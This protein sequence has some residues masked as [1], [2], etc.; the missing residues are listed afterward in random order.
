MTRMIRGSVLLAACVGLWSCSSDPTA[1]EAGVP[2]KIVSLPSVVFV[3]QDSSELIG[4][5]LVD[6]LDG[7][8]PET[9]TV[10][11]NTANFSVALDPSFRPVYNP[12]GTL[13]LPDEQTE[14]RATIT[15]LA[16]GV[17]SLTV[18]A[19]GKSLTVTVNVIPG[20]LY[21]TFAPAAPAPGDTVTMTMPPTL[22]LTPASV[23]TFPGNLAP[24]IV[25]T[26]AERLADSSTIR[27]ISAPTTDTTASVTK[28]LNT[29][30]PTW[31]TVA[32]T[33]TWTLSSQF[34]VTG[35]QSGAWNGQLPATLS[36]LVGGVLTVTLN[37]PFAFKCNPTCAN[38]L[39]SV[40]SFPTQTAPIV[41]SI[42]ADS[43]VANLSIG[44]NVASPLLVTRI[45][46]KG[47]PQ[48]EYTV[49]SADSV[50][51][52]VIANFTATLSSYTPTIVTPIVLT[53]GAGFSFSATAVPTWG[54][55][56]PARV[57]SRTANSLTVQPAPGS[58]GSPSSV[59]GVISASAPAF[60][61]TIPAVLQ[62]PLAMQ[63]TTGASPFVGQDAFATAPAVTIN[64]YMDT[65]N[66]TAAPGC[67][68]GPACKVYRFTVAAAG[69]QTFTMNWD[70]SYTGA[71]TP[72]VDLGL[73][74]LDLDGVVPVPLRTAD[75]PFLV[76]TTPNGAGTVY[77]ACDE[78]GRGGFETC[79]MNFPAAGTYYLEISTFTSPY[80]TTSAWFNVGIQ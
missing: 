80:A 17:S 54:A 3:K 79:T 66:F 78:F 69:N 49:A 31:P 46:F 61:V 4:F 62:S 20:T 43:L 6:Q 77:F 25:S 45:T 67:Y 8:I 35:T 71:A 22:R 47:A 36:P 10:G 53:A 16:L 75:Y 33:V 48:F 13:T 65:G 41:N 34:K 28:V 60:T 11:A 40:F 44:P 19:G 18:S 29:E 30:F 74:V 63:T 12:D 39:P 32:D 51:S 42:S 37:A 64:G 57:L 23:I 14:V 38:A 50:I 72:G 55:A 15:G 27:F 76:G 58:A 9:W 56:G 1:D 59:T 68:S 24:V 21:A 2:Y 7:Q 70:N 5:Q 73:Y 52:A 26:P